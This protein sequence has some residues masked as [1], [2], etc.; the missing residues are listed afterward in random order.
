VDVL[1]LRDVAEFCDYFRRDDHVT[2][3]EQV[4]ERVGN[5][6]TDGCIRTGHR[7][8]DERTRVGDDC[9]QSW[10]ASSIVVDR[11]VDRRHIPIVDVDVI[12]GSEIEWFV[13]RDL[14]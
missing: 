8:T 10:T 11:G 12:G 1:I 3:G 13:P 9:S 6:G 4:L 5:I 14:L 7:E 2:G